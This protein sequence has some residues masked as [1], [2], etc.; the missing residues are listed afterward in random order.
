MAATID[1]ELRRAVAAAAAGGDA[2]R[3]SALLDGCGGG[4]AL[5]DLVDALSEHALQDGVPCEL[6]PLMAAA[7]GA[8]APT[9]RVLM[10]RGA[11]ATAGDGRGRTGQWTPSNRWI[12]HGQVSMVKGD[13]QWQV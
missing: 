1:A 11:S 7:A 6:T 4:D 5:D 2:S 8:H 3:L 9:M 12:C 13:V 10:Q